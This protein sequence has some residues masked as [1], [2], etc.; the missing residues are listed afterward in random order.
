MSPCFCAS[1]LPRLS[2]LG[3]SWPERLHHGTIRTPARSHAR[4]PARSHARTLARPHA[5]TPARSHAR[6]PA[7]SHART[8]ARSH[9][10]TLARPHA[11]TSA[12]SHAR[13][14][15]RPHARTPSSPHSRMLFNYTGVPCMLSLIKVVFRE[16]PEN[17][18]CSSFHERLRNTA[19]KQL[20]EVSL[21]K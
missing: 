20:C 15:A 2:L 16:L 11:R 21:E 14:L 5:R 8:S 19:L 1:R 12:R 7:R 10:R 3:G 18:W 17:F 4:T 6:T 9:V 13:T